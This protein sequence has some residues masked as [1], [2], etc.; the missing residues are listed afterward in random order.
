V[1]PIEFKEMNCLLAKDQ[2]QYLQLP[3]HKSED[4]TVT[5]CWKLTWLDRLR[6][7]LFG[8]LWLQQL[9]FG[10][11]LQPQRPSVEKPI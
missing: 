3:A 4:G 10:D 7:C 6:V 11:P 2:P 8:R 1:K 9:T 5:S